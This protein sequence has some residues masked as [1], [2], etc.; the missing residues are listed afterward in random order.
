MRITKQD[1][2]HINVEFD[3]GVNVKNIEAKEEKTSFF[4]KL[5]PTLYTIVYNAYAKIRGLKHRVIRH[6]T[7]IYTV[8]ISVFQEVINGKK[9][10]ENKSKLIKTL[11]SES[12]FNRLIK[13]RYKGNTVDFLNSKDIKDIFK[14]LLQKNIQNRGKESINTIFCALL[15]FG[16]T[17]TRLSIINYAKTG[18]VGDIMKTY[19]KM[20]KQIIKDRTFFALGLE[21]SLHNVPRRDILDDDSVIRILNQGMFEENIDVLEHG[22]KLYRLGYYL[23]RAFESV[24]SKSLEEH[25]IQDD[26]DEPQLPERISKRLLDVYEDRGTETFHDVMNELIE[27]LSNKENKLDPPQLPEHISKRLLDVYEDR[28]TE[29]FHD[30]MNELIEELSNKENKLDPPHDDLVDVLTESLSLKKEDIPVVGRDQPHW[31]RGVKFKMWHF[32]DM[33]WHQFVELNTKKMEERQ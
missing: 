26:Q 32:A 29:T 1:D 30:A 24:R 13:E 3:H 14:L 16:R 6:E 21:V 27:E 28:G 17:I 9:Q 4:G 10:A 23:D 2:G 33:F 8:E 7:Q 25:I 11:A 12:G 19:R 15:N 18:D 5:L 20:E 31:C 22:Y